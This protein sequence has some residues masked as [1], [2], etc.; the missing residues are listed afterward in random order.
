MPLFLDYRCFELTAN[1]FV[2]SSDAGNRVTPDHPR[3][4]SPKLLPILV[5]ASAEMLPTGTSNRREILQ[6]RAFV[7]A[8]RNQHALWRESGE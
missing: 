8:R 6:R 7:P 2:R 5:V 4:A 1:R 3:V